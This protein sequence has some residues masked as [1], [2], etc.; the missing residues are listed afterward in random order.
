MDGPFYDYGTIV[1]S[2]LT[3]VFC[4]VTVAVIIYLHLRG[5]KAKGNNSSSALWKRHGII[6]FGVFFKHS[7]DTMALSSPGA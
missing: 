5:L 2:S 1:V 7:D 4:I 6:V 3:S